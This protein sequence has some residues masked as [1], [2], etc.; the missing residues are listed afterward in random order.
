MLEKAAG[1]A[2]EVVT[3]GD[4]ARGDAAAMIYEALA[5]QFGLPEANE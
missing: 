5:V 1:Y 4:L 2:P 3:D